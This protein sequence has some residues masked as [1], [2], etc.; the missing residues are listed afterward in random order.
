MSRTRTFI[1]VPAD[2]GVYAQA[3][4]AIKL[5]SP[6]TEN[7]RWTGADNLHWTLQFLGEVEDIETFEV[8]RAVAKVAAGQQAFELGSAGVRAFPNNEK[9]RTV[10]LGAGEGSDRLCE[11]QDAVE[12]SMADLGFRPERQRYT[13][14]LTLGRVHQGSHGGTALSEKLGTMGDPDGSSL[15]KGTMFVD[16]VLIFGSEI[17]RDGPSYHVLGRAP[18]QGGG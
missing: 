7:V 16:E 1:A 10:W 13:P 3:L 4:A 18:L 11:L 6:H 15:E 5:L 12:A 8:C 14:H 2:D 9:P 17:T